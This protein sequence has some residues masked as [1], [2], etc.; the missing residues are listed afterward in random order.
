M[1]KEQE[2]KRLRLLEKERERMARAEAARLQ[3]I[4]KKAT[5][6]KATTPVTCVLYSLTTAFV[7]IEFVSREVFILSVTA[8]F[9]ERVSQRRAETES[10]QDLKAQM[11]LETE[12]EKIAKADAMKREAM[13]QASLAARKSNRTNEVKDKCFPA[14]GVN[15]WL[16]AIAHP[17]VLVK[18]SAIDEETTRHIQAIHHDEERKEELVCN[19]HRYT[20]VQAPLPSRYC[21]AD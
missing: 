1:E 17:Q 8:H 13:L 12:K 20:L 16:R 9:R 7:C 15:H 4:N 19:K 2:E 18:K 10:C 5:A 3:T 6:A 14:M 21:C 11:V